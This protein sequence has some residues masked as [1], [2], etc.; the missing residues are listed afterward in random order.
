MYHQIRR[1]DTKRTVWLSVRGINS[2]NLELK[3][4][5]CVHTKPE[6]FGNRSMD[7]ALR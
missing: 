1:T 3:Q 6:E 4:L 2:L 5:N 7:A